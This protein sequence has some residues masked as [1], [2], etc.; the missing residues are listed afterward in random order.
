MTE[1]TLTAIH[2]NTT[3][4]AREIEM[5]EFYHDAGPIMLGTNI[6]RGQWKTVTRI[7]PYNEAGQGAEVPW[8][9][10]WD[11]DKLVCRV[12]ASSIAVVWYKKED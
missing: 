9:R 3:E 8:F 2:F 12:N 10:V 5:L 7:E 11:G 6:L 1:D 4:R